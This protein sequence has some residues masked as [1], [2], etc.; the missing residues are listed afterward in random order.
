MAYGSIPHTSQRLTLSVLN[1]G[2]HTV[3]SH[4]VLEV[5]VEGANAALLDIDFGTYPFATGQRTMGGRWCTGEESVVLAVQWWGRFFYFDTI[6][7]EHDGRISMSFCMSYFSR[8]FLFPDNTIEERN[9][10]G[11]H[12][13]RHKQT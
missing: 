6:D 4:R 1:A 11:C 10:G 9:D 5:L 8:V 7:Q 12:A 3:G 2:V 13:K